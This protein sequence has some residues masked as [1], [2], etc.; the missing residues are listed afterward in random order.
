MLEDLALSF[1]LLR[2][3]VVGIAK[4]GPVGLAV[5]YEQEAKDRV[6]EPWVTG[7]KIRRRLANGF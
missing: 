5:F 3:C 6:I 4:D 2:I 1:W 7:E